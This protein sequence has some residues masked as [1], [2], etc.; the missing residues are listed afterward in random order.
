MLSRMASESRDILQIE[1]EDGRRWDVPLRRH[2]L[3][4]G[5]SD[6]ADI[7]LDHGTVSRR[8]A[9]ISRDPFGRWWIRDLGSRN[10]LKVGANKV[11]EHLLSKGE[12]VRVGCFIVHLLPPRS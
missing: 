7:R 1:T 6:E 8:H 5:R 11:A 10:G 12:R 9:E 2:Q 3:T 4:I